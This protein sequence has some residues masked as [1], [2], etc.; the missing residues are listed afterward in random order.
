MC[1]KE[2]Y[3]DVCYK[4]VSTMK[5]TL[6]LWIAA[7]LAVVLSLP[8]APAFAITSQ[9][10]GHDCC[11]VSPAHAATGTAGDCSGDAAPHATPFCGDAGTGGSPWQSPSCCV[12]C[13][14]AA[15]HAAYSYGSPPAAFAVEASA[16][17]PPLRASPFLPAAPVDRFERPPKAFSF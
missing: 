7:V 12:H 15:V 3:P 14:V 6:R 1:I 5:R 2:P 9:G 13:A 8:A 11:V 10:E 17:I 16:Y 4:S